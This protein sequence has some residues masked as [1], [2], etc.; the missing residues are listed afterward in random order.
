MKLIKTLQQTSS[1][2]VCFL[3]KENES[4]FVLSETTE[5]ILNQ[6]TC[7]NQPIECCIS[8]VDGEAFNGSYFA[9]VLID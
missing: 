4:F 3:F 9:E 7:K 5:A 1:N 8:S 6:F 2:A